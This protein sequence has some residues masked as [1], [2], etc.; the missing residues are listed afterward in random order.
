MASGEVTKGAPGESEIVCGLINNELLKDKMVLILDDFV[1]TGKTIGGVLELVK[2]ARARDIK[3][4]VL[5]KKSARTSMR[6]PDFVGFDLG[7]DSDK[8]SSAGAGKCWLF[9]YGMD[10]EG[11]YRE[12]DHVGWVRA[13]GKES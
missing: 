1:E 10:Y 3:I 13:G 4:G 11:H 8:L 6:P 5:I 7:L 2:D 9:G 12:L